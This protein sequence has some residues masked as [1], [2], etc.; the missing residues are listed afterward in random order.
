MDI[1]LTQ[2]GQGHFVQNGSWTVNEMGANAT[3]QTASLSANILQ[4]LN[5][6][7]GLV[8]DEALRKFVA[9]YKWL[10][11]LLCILA[12]TFCCINA[13]VYWQQRAASFAAYL[14]SVDVGDGICA[15]A[16]LVHSLMILTLPSGAYALQFVRW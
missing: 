7:E 9:V 3:V 8:S 1:S 5:P 16:N 15:S 11:P 12:V 6:D 14:F 13:S 4:V 2:P 10:M